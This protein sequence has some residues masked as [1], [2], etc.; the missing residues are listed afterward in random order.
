MLKRRQLQIFTMSFLDCITAGFGAVV[1]LFMLISMQTGVKE[2]RAN[3][4]LAAESMKMEDEVLEG[5]KNL[6]LLRNSLDKTS[7]EKTRASGRIE[8]VLAELQ[9]AREDLSKYSGDSQA[10][11]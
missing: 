3:D 5:Y 4:A 8:Q 1:L 7:T 6:V 2:I 10:R 9:K 11:R